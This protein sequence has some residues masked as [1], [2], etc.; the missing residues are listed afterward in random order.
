MN[1]TQGQLIDIQT[2]KPIIKW[3][4]GKTAISNILTKVVNLANKER[5]DYYEPFFGGGGLFFKLCTEDKIKS[6][7]INDIIPHLV[8][9][10]QTIQNSSINNIYEEILQ[11]E[12]QFN[13]QDNEEERKKIY[14]HWSDLFNSLWVDEKQINEQED[15]ELEEYSDPKISKTIKKIEYTERKL[16]NEVERVSSACLFL[17][18]NKAGFNGMF[19]LNSN[20]KFNIPIGDK[21]ELKI[22]DKKSLKNTSK[23]LKDVEINC[24]S[25]EEILPPNKKIDPK[26]SFIY[27]DPPYIPNS[28]TASFTDYSKEGFKE[29]DHIKLAEV[30]QELVNGGY[31]VVLSNNNNPEAVEKYV[32]GTKKTFAYEVMVSR[33]IAST[34]T[35]KKGVSTRPKVSELLVSS[36]NLDELGLT[37]IDS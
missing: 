10:Y 32:K 29:E 23:A 31:K 4:G 26:T 34:V 2:Y 21:T 19:R 9:F 37:K 22:V 35:D 27:L 17:A 15:K 8:S 11:L 20:G 28:K 14:N 1:A 24:G 7:T 12:E 16:K 5:I 18:L 6:A 36:F 33:Q 13:K 25:Y 30:F 3:A